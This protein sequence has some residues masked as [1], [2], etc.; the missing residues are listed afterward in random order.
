M[1]V[2]TSILVV[3]LWIFTSVVVQAKE[4]F[5]PPFKA[6]YQLYS[7]GLPVGQGTR[8]L[9]YLENGQ[10]KFESNS[11]TTGMLA[12]FRD[13]KIF[14]Q[15]IFSLKN[16]HVLPLVYVYDR[17]SSKKPKY[18]KV[19]FDWT[20][21]IADSTDK[22]D[23]WHVSITEGTLDKL[24]Y[25]LVVM[26]DL[27]QGKRAL[28][29]QFVDEDEVKTYIPEFL[30]KERIETGMGMM[31]TLKYQRVSSNQKRSTTLWCAPELHYLPVRV[32]HDEKGYLISTVLQ[33]VEG[34]GKVTKK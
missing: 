16:D 33:S 27:M 32:D 24:V 12:L 2:K 11:H 18:L 9:S 14:E 21:Q 10:L 13:D 7:S 22:Q 17:K 25:Q 8:Q 26:Q 19:N 30:G 15:S 3:G 4:T 23:S 34:L 1:K 31:D 29:Y 20:N 5:P 28:S 6:H